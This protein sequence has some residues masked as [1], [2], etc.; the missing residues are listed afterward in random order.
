MDAARAG[1]SADADVTRVERGTLS[2]KKGRAWKTSVGHE[3]G[4]NPSWVREYAEGE[5][6]S[7]R[8]VWGLVQRG[9]WGWSDQQGGMGGWLDPTLAKQDGKKSKER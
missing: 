5:G 1:R 7:T 9:C 2:S 4:M 6:G 3:A 8:G